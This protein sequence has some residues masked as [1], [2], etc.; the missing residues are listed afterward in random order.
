MLAEVVVQG[1]K[2]RLVVD[3]QARMVKRTD[4]AAYEDIGAC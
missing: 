1:W 4:S 3:I 2:A